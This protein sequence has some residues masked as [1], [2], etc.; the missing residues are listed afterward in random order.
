[1]QKAAC[2]SMRP[3]SEA[4]R[5]TITAL[6]ARACMA[7]GVFPGPLRHASRIRAA[8]PAFGRGTRFGRG[9]S[10]GGAERALGP[11]RP[12]AIGGAASL[13]LGLE[14]GARAVNL[15]DRSQ[16]LCLPTSEVTDV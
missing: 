7:R 3:T 9:A 16:A 15:R 10:T 2:L 5:R 4:R 14:W 6:E 13:R 11:F 12:T 8:L 1:M